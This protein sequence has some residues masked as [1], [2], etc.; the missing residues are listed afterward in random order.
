[1][2]LQ[3]RLSVAQEL[4]NRGYSQPPQVMTGEGGTGPVTITVIG[5]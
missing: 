1:V 2:R 4:L 5:A 3:T